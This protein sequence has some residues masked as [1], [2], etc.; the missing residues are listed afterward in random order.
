MQASFWHGPFLAQ[1]VSSITSVFPSFLE[2]VRPE[3]VL[4]I[5]TG[6]GGFTYLLHQ[7]LSVPILSCDVHL[8]SPDVVRFCQ[9]HQADVFD[10]SFLSEVILPF[11]GPRGR[12]LVLCDGS[13]KINEFK[14]LAPY[15]QKGDLIM[16][17]DYCDS[18]SLFN[19]HYL[20]KVWDWC[21]ITHSDI[22][23]CIEE[24]GLRPHVW[25]PELQEVMWCC[26]E[27]V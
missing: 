25:H 16:A 7:S 12:S 8:F 11:L 18:R 17:H 5:G 22:S 26:Y 14:L 10:P 13:D 23:D 6:Y 1:Q 27:R 2:A 9:W 15:L 4:E 19:E 20:G 24:C 3:R 21:E